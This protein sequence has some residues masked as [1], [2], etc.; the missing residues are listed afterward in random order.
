MK[1]IQA[2][3]RNLLRAQA[4]YP[5]P[6]RPL[7][8]APVGSGLL[9]VP[10]DSG[11]PL[12]GNTVDMLGNPLGNVLRQYRRYGQVSWSRWFGGNIVHLIGPDAIEAAWMDRDGVMS[13]ELGWGQLIGPFFDRGLMLLDFA[14]HRHHRRIMQAAFT[15]RRLDGYLELMAPLVADHIS[16]WDGGQGFPASARIK[17]L[18]LAV[19][20]EVFMGSE[21][22]PEHTRRLEEAFDA[23]VHGGRA[24][25]RADVGNF[26]WARGLR[27]REMLQEYFR[28]W[29]PARRAG[30]GG[31]LFTVL[32]NSSD[33]DGNAFT[34]E[35]VVNHMIFAMMAAHDTTSVALSMMVYYLGLHRD[36]QD[37]L[38]EESCELGDSAITVKSLD[39]LSGMDLVFR[40]TVRINAPVG[41]IFRK[42]VRDTDILGHYI[43]QG[44]LV[45]IHPWAT[46]QLPEWWPEPKR[47][48]PERFSPERSEDRVHRFAWAP[49]G[50]GAHRCI[51]MYFAAMEA[52]LILH[53]LLTKFEW[54]VPQGYRIRFTYGTGAVPADGLPIDVCRLRTPRSSVVH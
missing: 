43:P 9:S 29:I 45:G 31:D 36:W 51:G 25:L 48:D 2:V 14:E 53:Q 24:F 22:A 41:M 32:C 47:W 16:E 27:G 4:G 42:T 44:C 54:S 34:D 5:R 7:A 40:E 28:S 30:S 52:K 12:V 11:L 10:G 3:R 26:T 23:T 20:S 8:P 49:F 39:A 19:A 37:R 13:S 38:R 15:P 50:S 6:E 33:E 21:L 1:S 18:L 46:M 17:G 35:D